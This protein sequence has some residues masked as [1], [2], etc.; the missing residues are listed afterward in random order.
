MRVS[1]YKFRQEEL[2]VVGEILL[3][4]FLRDREKF[5]NFSPEFN[6]EFVAAIQNQIQKVQDITQA[7]TLTAEIKKITEELYQN[8]E[9]LLPNLDLILAYAQRANKNLNIKASGFG[10]KEAK[11]ELR[12]RNVEGFSVKV[13]IV[14][15]NIAKNL[16]ALIAKGYKE[17]IGAEVEEITQK[18]HDLNLEQ[19][20]KLSER[21][22]LV[23]GNNEEFTAL[24]K[25]LGDI[26]KTGKL[27]MKTDPSKA[28]EYMFSHVIKKVRRVSVT[29]DKK[30]TSVRKETNPVAEV[31][32]SNTKETE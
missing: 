16:E 15:Q 23:V 21:K 11:K 2:P 32:G 10:V 1:Y 22:Q 13:K 7:P 12:R 3:Q 24:W 19:E 29:S 14:Q 27:V 8:M 20:N 9:N 18:V 25:L 5:E 17:S 4:M 6:D 28:E 30:K 31:S 26:S